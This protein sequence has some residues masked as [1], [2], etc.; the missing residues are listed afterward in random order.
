[1]TM[2]LTLCA[3]SLRSRMGN[4]SSGKRGGDGMNMLE[5]PAFVVKHLQ[6]HGLNIPASMLAGW[7][8]EDLDRLRDAADKA[9][10]PCLVLI[11]DAPRPLGS[12]D[13][14]VREA[15]AARIQRLAFA[16]NRL[17]CNAV[18]LKIDAPN[19]NESFDI[20]ADQVRAMLPA[21]ER[22]ELNVLLAPHAGLTAS[23]ERLTS[24]IKRVGGFRI[25]SL[26]SF[27]AAAEA[28]DGDPIEGLRKLA[29]YA[30][31][32]HATVEGFNKK[33]AHKS[34]DLVA[35]VN[36]IRSVGFLNTLAIDY[37]GDGDPV[38]SIEKARDLLQA[39]IDK[40]AE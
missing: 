29:P 38:P 18:A 10:C 20:A 40:E 5:V 31:A 17:G 37:T 4:A 24:L 32:I 8:P 22:L 21:I 25:G 34:W 6:L 12:P 26:P 27:G 35:C 39:A 7:S 1:M 2:L 3:G 15:A 11:E 30:G 14:S 23:T 16:A 19:D 36:A 33:G 28:G 9:A 13:D